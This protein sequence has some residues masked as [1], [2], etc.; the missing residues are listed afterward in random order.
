[1]S[2]LEKLMNDI[3]KD[4]I[5]KAKN[6]Y[7]KIYPCVNKSSLS[8]CFTESKNGEL[9]FWFNTPDKSTHMVASDDI[10]VY[11]VLTVDKLKA[12]RKKE[13]GDNQAS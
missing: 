12:N 1:M 10:A 8:E 11:D 6:I 9:V 3:K 5:K 2:Y 4:L 13:S 7:G